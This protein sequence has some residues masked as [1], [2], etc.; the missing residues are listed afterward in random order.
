MIRLKAFHGLIS[1]AMLIARSPHSSIKEF[2][3]TFLVICLVE[4][5]SLLANASK[6]RLER[7][8]HEVTTSPNKSNKNGPKLQSHSACSSHIL[9][10]LIYIIVQKIWTTTGIERSW[11]FALCSKSVPFWGPAIQKGYLPA[12][13]NKEARLPKRLKGLRRRGH[14]GCSFIQD[15]VDV[16]VEQGFIHLNFQAFIMSVLHL[17]LYHFCLR[18]VRFVQMGTSKKKTGNRRHE[19]LPFGNM[20]TFS[21]QPTS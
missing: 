19:H 8:K 5:R 2:I 20:T 17:L 4:G 13:V 16:E 12:D 15:F 10:Q 14:F 18:H 6:A 7:D 21:S 3:V 9:W 11:V 1:L